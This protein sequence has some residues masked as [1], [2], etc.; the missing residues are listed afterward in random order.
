MAALFA[1]T[2][3]S[4]TVA[5]YTAYISRAYPRTQAVRQLLNGG[6]VGDRV[7]EIRYRLCGTGGA[8]DVDNTS[9][10]DIAALAVGRG[11]VGRGVA[12]GRGMSRAGS[13]RLLVWTHS[14]GA[15]H[16]GGTP[17]R[18]QQR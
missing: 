15:R 5:F 13:D 8:R 1:A 16:G 17:G 10:K 7:T 3:P 11:P 12:P 4:S 2:T 9:T 18:P 14:I 6:A